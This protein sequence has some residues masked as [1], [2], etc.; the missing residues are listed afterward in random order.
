MKKMKLAISTTVLLAIL[1]IVGFSDFQVASAREA[2][3]GV[4]CNCMYTQ[5]GPGVIKDND[6]VLENCWVPIEAS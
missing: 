5:T 4:K 2:A 3:V 1:G 6:C